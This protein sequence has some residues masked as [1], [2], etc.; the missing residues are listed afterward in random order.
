MTTVSGEP[1]PDKRLWLLY[2]CCLKP[3]GGNKASGIDYNDGHDDDD[4]YGDDE[5]DGD[6]DDDNAVHFHNGPP[7][8]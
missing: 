8:H 4:N 3:V 6:D 7:M 2:L 1:R 5:D